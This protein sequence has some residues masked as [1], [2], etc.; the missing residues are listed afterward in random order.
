MCAFNNVT[1]LRRNFAVTLDKITEITSHSKL[2]TSLY[3]FHFIKRKLFF[4]RTL[5][6][7]ND[8]QIPSDE[9]LAPG[10]A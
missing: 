2:L 8:S 5:A 7:A 1:N 6:E 3:L 9:S 4:T 10:T